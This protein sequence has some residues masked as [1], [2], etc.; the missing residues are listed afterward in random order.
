MFVTEDHNDS[1]AKRTELGGLG[2][3]EEDSKFEIRRIVT[4]VEGGLFG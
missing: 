4:K 2:H 3:Q 1:Q